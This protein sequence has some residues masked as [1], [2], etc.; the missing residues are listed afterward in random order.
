MSDPTPEAVLAANI[1]F[2]TA[3]AEDYDRNQPHF[4]P[5]NVARVDEILRR[6]AQQV[7]GGSLI[8]LGCGTGFILNLAKRHFDRVVGVDATPAMLERVDTSGGNVET[9]LA[10][11]DA[12]P[13]S[14][15]EFDA[16]T[17]YGYL[18]H[19]YDLEP[20]FGEAAR[21]LRAGGRFFSDQDPNDLYWQHLA[22]LD[23]RDDLQGFVRREV[24]SVVATDELAADETQLSTTEVQL[25]EYQKMRL[26]GLRAD[27][28]VEKLRRVG[29]A[30]ASY[31]Y[32]WY[33][34]QGVVLHEHGAETNGTV[35]AYL[36]DALPASA[37]LFKYVAFYATR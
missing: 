14:D 17:A 7:G 6:I 4:L 26:G 20:T 24:T 5:E 32:E 34:G 13:F 23:G 35:E 28:V 16:C 1:A 33:L 15:G 37:P 22:N 29:F 21:V 9:C 27:D 36:R 3:L 2:H 11:T 10:T 12:L 30:E 31:R 8:D 25:A 18:H 19:L